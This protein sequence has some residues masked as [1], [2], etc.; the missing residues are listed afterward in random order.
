MNLADA[1]LFDEL[2]LLI[3]SLSDGKSK[4][5]LLGKAADAYGQGGIARIVALAGTPYPC[6]LPARL[7]PKTAGSFKQPDPQ[8]GGGWKPVTETILGITDI[9]KRIIDG[10]TYADPCKEP[11]WIAPTL[12]FRKTSAILGGEHSISISHAKASQ[13]L[14]EMGYG[15]Q[16][17][18]KMGQS[19]LPSPDRNGQFEFIGL[20]AHEYLEARDPVI[21]VDTKK[22][23]DIG[24]FKNNGAECRKGKDP[25]R[26]LDHDSPVPEPGK[27]APHG[28]YALNDNTG[29][30]NRLR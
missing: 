23:E 22:K 1:C 26:A 3:N 30:V 15:K 21:S 19:G 25:R 14:S 16:A 18:Q 24:S 13:L 28:V 4:R 10:N 27:A 11:H 7:I 29:F 9:I 8:G 12:S 6:L 17:N 2:V 20:A 5:I